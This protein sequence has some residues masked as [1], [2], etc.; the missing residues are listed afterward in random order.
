MEYMVV[1]A[2]ERHIVE[3]AAVHRGIER[4]AMARAGSWYMTDPTRFW[5]D[6]APITATGSRPGRGLVVCC[7]DPRP[8]AIDPVDGQRLGDV[9]LSCFAFWRVRDSIDQA[10]LSQSTGS[11]YPSTQDS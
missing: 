8:N 7:L 1:G 6:D 10:R 3:S 9:S 4:R 5:Q 2:E 11:P